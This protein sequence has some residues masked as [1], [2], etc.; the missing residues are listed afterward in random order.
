[1]RE[2]LKTK[3][4]IKKSLLCSFE[5]EEY[6]IDLNRQFEGYESGDLICY[7]Y[8]FYSSKLPL[9]L[10]LAIRQNGDLSFRSWKFTDEQQICNYL[11]TSQKPCNDED[12][13][14]TDSFIPT[15]AQID[16]V[17]GLFSGRILFEGLSISIGKTVQEICPIDVEKE[18]KLINK[19]I[20]LNHPH[21]KKDYNER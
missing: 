7:I 15:E 5:G 19:K 2:N 6:I 14:I 21:T 16:T 17:N 9:R 12:V 1:M 20:Y 3:I 10:E 11:Q 4:S 18:E 13:L 8:P